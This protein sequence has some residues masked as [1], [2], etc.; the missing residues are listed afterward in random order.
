M[1]GG[2]RK[3]KGWGQPGKGKNNQKKMYKPR[4]GHKRS[5]QL[6]NPEKRT[7]EVVVCGKR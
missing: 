4:I 3:I 5:W 2:R 1:N 7:Y 6:P